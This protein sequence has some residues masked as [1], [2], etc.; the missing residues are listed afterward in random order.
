MNLSEEALRRSSYAVIRKQLATAT[1][2]TLV[3][4]LDSRSIKVGDTAADLLATRESLEIV[5]R[6]LLQRSLRSRTAKIRA[7]GILRQFGKKATGAIEV[8]LAYLTDRSLDVVADALFGLVFWQDAQVTSAIR[9]AMVSSAHDKE[10]RRLFS[11]AT[12]ALESQNPFVFSPNYRD[13]SNVWELD[14]ARFPSG[15]AAMRQR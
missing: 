7:F 13:A 3:A 12:E 5:T 4:L 2:E 14:K 8:Y 1:D 11:K 6:A 15:A 10:R 9:H